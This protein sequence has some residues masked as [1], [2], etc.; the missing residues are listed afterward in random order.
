M[1]R[2]RK[3]IKRLAAVVLVLIVLTVSTINVS[4]SYNYDLPYDFVP[5]KY[6]PISLDKEHTTDEKVIEMTEYCENVST[7]FGLETAWM[8]YGVPEGE[9][10]LVYETDEAEAD[11]IS[12]LNRVSDEL[13]SVYFLSPDEADS[14]LSD[15]YT[16]IQSASE[17]MNIHSYEVS[18]L[19]KICEEENNEKGF[20]SD[21]SWN[22]FTTALENAKNA[23]ADT[24]Q[25]HSSQIYWDLYFAYNQLCM[26]YGEPGDVDGDGFADIIDVTW[27]QRNLVG[28]TPRFNAAQR[29][30][31]CLIG[32]GN[33]DDLY[34]EIT[35]ATALQRW[36]AGLNPRIVDYRI[37]EN[38]AAIENWRINPIVAHAMYARMLPNK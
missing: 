6:T 38:D 20:Y 21:Q 12:V 26:Q 23:V 29:C 17:K 19:I 10:V 22:A 1:K 3:F 14:L 4:A 15:Y 35:D 27:I 16:M 24:S 33:S 9:P 31:G 30:A 11:L 37:K 13:Y 25:N 36:L 32:R 2:N 8:E 28:M 18:F 5:W 7:Y 34:P